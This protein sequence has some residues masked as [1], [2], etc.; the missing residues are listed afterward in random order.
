MIESIP[1]PE[2]TELE[3]AYET[4]QELELKIKALQAKLEMKNS[5][6]VKSLEYLLNTLKQALEHY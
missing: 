4:I 3:T 1:V 6:R 5:D 2:Q